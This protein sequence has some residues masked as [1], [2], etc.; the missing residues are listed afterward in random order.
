MTPAPYDLAIFGGGP[1]GSALALWTAAQTTRPERLLVLDRQSEAQAQTDPRVIA[2]SAGSLQLLARVA[3]MDELV[4]APITRIHV[5]QIGHLG[6]TLLDAREDHVPAYGVV[7]RYGEL[8]RVLGAALAQSGVQVRRP[9][10]VQACEEAADGVRWTLQAGT[11]A[12][13]DAHAAIAVHA[14]GGLFQR[15]DA[16]DAH[17]RRDYGQSAVI[18]EIDSDRRH[19]GIAYER[20]GAHGPVALLPM[21]EPTRYALV[22]CERP[23]RANEIAAL[24]ETDFLVQLQAA[25]GHRAGRFLRATP[26]HAYAL[27]LVRQR[28]TAARTVRIGNAAQALHPVTGQGLNLGLRDAYALARAIAQYG[29]SPEAITH[30]RAERR[31]DR[32]ATVRIT[33]GLARGFALPLAPVRHAAG[34]GLLA[35]DLASPLRGALARQMMFGVRD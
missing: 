1:V 34:L 18:S 22:W 11:E 14:E 31:A 17:T 30:M 26:A 28:D 3:P 24:G 15:A 29:T 5:S 8:M 25:F 10:A 13:T 9:V 6:R 27:G 23:E 35:L 7:V 21:P 2:L 20:F 33:D 32:W 12:S 16:A 19:G 4:A